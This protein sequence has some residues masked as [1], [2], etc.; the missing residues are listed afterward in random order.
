[1]EKREAEREKK[2]VAFHQ[3]ERHAGGNKESE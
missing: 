3:R 2:K 1:M